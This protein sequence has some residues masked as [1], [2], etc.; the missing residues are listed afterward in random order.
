[1]EIYLDKK[2]VLKKEFTDP[3]GLENKE[4]LKQYAGKYSIN[5]PA[6]KHK[7]TIKNSGKDWFEIL[8]YFIPNYIIAKKPSLRV[9]G[10]IGKSKGLIWLQSPHYIW[11]K[12]YASDYKPH[13]Y[14]GVRLILKNIPAG[15]WFVKEFNTH[16]GGINSTKKVKVG[17]DG[18][19]TINLPEISW[20][21]AYKLSRN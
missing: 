6:G 1:M 9:T 12:V 20:D 11:S 21:I 8:E 19:L 18:K 15:E 7:I 17:A 10:I 13:I 14:K 3:D 4:I 16:T 2:L 5:L